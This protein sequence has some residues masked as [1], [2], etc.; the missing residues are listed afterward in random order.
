MSSRWPSSLLNATNKRLTERI[1]QLT[2]D[3]NT[4]RNSVAEQR[5]VVALLK[6]HQHEAQQQVKIA[7]EA[8]ECERAAV[9]NDEGKLKQLQLEAEADARRARQSKEAETQL[10]Q[11]VSALESTLDQRCRALSGQR[12]I[13]VELEKEARELVSAH[14]SRQRVGDELTAAQRELSSTVWS[15]LG[16]L[17]EQVCVATRRLEEVRG[18]R[19][20]VLQEVDA[21]HLALQ[22]AVK[23]QAESLRALE[24]V[25]VQTS[26]LDAQVLANAKSME[27]LVAA[28]RERKKLRG[29]LQ[30]TLERLRGDSQRQALAH[31]L[32]RERYD[33]QV[34]AL[35][36]AVAA[37]REDE[38]H[39][40]I[41]RR[42]EQAEVQQLCQQRRELEHVILLCEEKRQL[43]TQKQARRDALEGARAL[44]QRQESTGQPSPA[45]LCDMILALEQQEALLEDRVERTCAKLT[46]AIQTFM[47]EGRRGEHFNAAVA[48]KMKAK[49]SLVSD[50]EAS[51]GH[52]QLLRERGRKVEE[53]LT[54]RQAL[55]SSMQALAL[56]QRAQ[57]QASW[58]REIEQLRGTL[59]RVQ[60][61]HQ[62]LLHGTTTL[63]SSWHHT[64]KALEEKG[65]S[66]VKVLSDLR[67][68]EAE[69]SRLD[70]EMSAAVEEHNSRLLQHEQAG[71]TLQ[72]L[73]KAADAQVGALKEAAGAEA[74]IR[75]EVQIVEE[76]IQADMQGA[77]VE[78]HL[79]ENEVHE[80]SEEL[81][82]HRKKLNLLRLRYEEVVTSMAR[83]A[84]KPL[85]EEEGVGIPLPLLNSASD[86]CTPEAVHAHLL[87]RRSYEREQL[88]QRGN[89]LD[90][91]L[92]ALDKETSTLRH[93][94]DGLR[95]SRRVTSEHVN[96]LGE[97]FS[98]AKRA[99]ASSIKNCSSQLAPSA[100]SCS[101]ALIK[102]ELL[103]SAKTS[104]H[105]LTAELQLLDE[106]LAAMS[107]QR[108]DSRVRLHEMRATLKELQD[109]ERQKRMQVQKLRESAQRSRKL[110]N[111]VSVKCSR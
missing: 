77:L 84:Q 60:R 110:A 58:L 105:Y 86:T 73:M 63:R 106:T 34:H 45:A 59:L 4:K 47:D 94:L 91:R 92:V 78:L 81:Q 8:L 23:D 96:A 43:L 12:E 109:T 75:A 35:Q 66:Q 90:L 19:L 52:V 3:L 15:T 107:Q 25:Y 40:V 11:A 99:G 69:V 21:M 24:L 70:Q 31:D 53:A 54:E 32:K 93:M 108:D 48:D 30:A 6:K 65:M 79:N 50:Q 44:M 36:K 61:D 87:L 38:E 41:L 27:V 22:Y 29:E 95:S 28:A 42:C 80:L 1:E 39:S 97:V 26:Q 82:R 9:E 64:R 62:Q 16:R 46:G 55:L 76:R 67:L 13:A 74:Y 33:K 100:P 7:A 102:K 103:S 37:L 101:P 51:E 104:E 88:M 83:A 20:H 72:S 57:R 18:E 49:L 2:F 5:E 68:L 111:V 89:Y 85:N 98:T 56:E 17:N 71:V 10:S 14:L